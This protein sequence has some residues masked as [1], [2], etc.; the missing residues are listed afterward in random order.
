MQQIIASALPTAPRAQVPAGAASHTP[1]RARLSAQHLS[2]RSSRSARYWS[3]SD[4]TGKSSILCR[5]MSTSLSSGRMFFASSLP[6]PLS[7]VLTTHEHFPLETVCLATIP[8][9][10]ENKRIFFFL[11]GPCGGFTPA[12]EGEPPRRWAAR[13]AGV[14]D[15]ACCMNTW[16]GC[17]RARVSAAA[18]PPRC[19]NLRLQR[20][21]AQVVAPALARAARPPTIGC[22]LLALPARFSSRMIPGAG[23]CTHAACCGGAGAT[24]N[25]RWFVLLEM[26]RAGP[27]VGAEGYR[28]SRCQ[29]CRG[30]KRQD[31]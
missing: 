31:G 20:S 25:P 11:A 5:S 23:R 26:R 22:R 13:A 4:C 9:K 27:P 6:P 7:A 14:C 1:A 12:Q 15:A 24:R 2:A 19:R 16:G 8:A 21:A 29:G 28:G 17:P 3:V 30:G 18:A 10:N